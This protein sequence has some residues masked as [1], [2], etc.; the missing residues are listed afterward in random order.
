MPNEGT[1][2]R[3]STFPEIPKLDQELNHIINEQDKMN[4]IPVDKLP[5]VGQQPNGAT[6]L[7]RQEDNSYYIHKKLDGVFRELKADS[8]GKVYWG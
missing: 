3:H 5:A 6:F 8:N 2:K 1:Q 7:V 4:G